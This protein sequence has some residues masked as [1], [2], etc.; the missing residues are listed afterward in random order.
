MLKRKTVGVFIPILGA[1]AAAAT[2][3]GSAQAADQAV[4]V[5]FDRSGSMISACA[6]DPTVMKAKCGLTALRAPNTGRLWKKNQDFPEPGVVDYYFW[7]FRDRQTPP[8]DPPSSASGG[9]PD[10]I[11][12]YDTIAKLPRE[13]EDKFDSGTL[14]SQGIDS[15]MID[16]INKVSPDHPSYD[17]PQ[18]ND[19]TPLAQAYCRAVDFL[20]TQA[21]TLSKH[22]LLVSD[23]DQN[24][25]AALAQL[26]CNGPANTAPGPFKHP[27][28]NVV[29]TEA[30]K[31]SLFTTSGTG[32]GLDIGSWQANMMDKAISGAVH[33][34]P[35]S[36]PGTPDFSTCMGADCLPFGFKNIAGD[37]FQANGSTVITDVLFLE[38]FV[39]GQQFLFNASS[40]TLSAATLEGSASPS[41]AVSA[42][43]AAPAALPPASF[44]EFLSGLSQVTGGRTTIPG[45]TSGSGDPFGEHAVPGDTDDSGCVDLTDFVL[46]QASFGKKVELENPATLLAD[47]NT[48]GKIDEFDYAEL[49]RNYGQGCVL[50]PEPLPLLSNVLFGFG[51]VTN[52]SPA[53]GSSPDTLLSLTPRATEGSAALKVG[54]TGWRAFTSIPFSTSLI[55]DAARHVELDVFVPTPV[56]NP[57]WFGSVLMIVSSPSAN[58]YGSFLGNASLSWLPTNQFSTLRFDLPREVRK[59][60]RKQHEDFTVTIVVNSFDTGHVVDNLRFVP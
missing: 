15:L 22:I 60:I 35:A 29:R 55:D 27:P 50:P 59:A 4:L 14:I 47:L 21:P 12:N 41:P 28:Y 17:P 23:G 25:T 5:L 11:L 43:A 32:A 6:S 7:E 53:P 33:L 1:V 24:P 51:D 20:Q 42:F 54:G 49:K 39:Q 44:V 34:I 13:Y 48:D 3:A 30:T 56:A 36:F 9:N 26:D 46:L 10:I 18:G 2:F 52:W 38:D 57:W 19:M 45:R 40:K 8:L 31:L 58:I 16:A 37:A